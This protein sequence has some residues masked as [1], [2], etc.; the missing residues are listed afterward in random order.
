MC[1]RPNQECHVGSVAKPPV[2][3]IIVFGTEQRK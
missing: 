2:G 1:A 3:T